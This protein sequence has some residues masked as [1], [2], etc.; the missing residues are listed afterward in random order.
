LVELGKV[1]GREGKEL[2]VRLI[3]GDAHVQNDLQN[4]TVQRKVQCVLWLAKFESVTQVRCD[5]C[6][7]FNEKPPHESNIRHWER[8]L[9][10]M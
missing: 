2:R 9:K 7:L 5:Y 1:V 10:E 8:Q 4:V 6:H 3:Q